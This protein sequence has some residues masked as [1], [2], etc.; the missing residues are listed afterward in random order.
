MSAQSLFAGLSGTL[1]KPGVLGVM[2]VDKQGLC[3]HAEGSAT[4]ASAGAIGEISKHA[5]TLC[6]DGAVVTIETP[7][8]KVLLSRVEDVTTALFMDPA[9]RGPSSP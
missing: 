5:L 6:G 7:Q 2:A 4:G 8:S 3:L 9:T 1:E